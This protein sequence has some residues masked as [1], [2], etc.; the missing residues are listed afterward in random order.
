[1]AD[2]LC[3]TRFQRVRRKLTRWKRV[4]QDESVLR[5][6]CA[7]S[8]R[9]G[10]CIMW[11]TF[12][13]CPSF[14]DTLETC[15]AIGRAWT[16]EFDGASFRIGM[17]RG[18]P[19]SLR[20][21]WMGVFPRGVSW[22]SCSFFGTN[23]I[24]KSDPPISTRS[25]GRSESGSRH[26]LSRRNGST[27]RR[28]LGT[29]LIRV[30]AAVVQHPAPPHF[31]GQRY[32]LIAWVTGAES[33]S[34]GVSTS[35]GIGRQFGGFYRRPVAERTDSTQRQPPFSAKECNRIR[36]ATG[37]FWQRESYD[38]CVRDGDEL[39]RIVDYIHANPVKAGLVQRA[40]DF[41][42][43]S[44]YPDNRI[45]VGHVSNVSLE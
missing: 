1:M 26:S 19:I 27:I 7:G 45:H 2:Q 8:L 31:A 3:G 6:S 17:C 22:T 44:A 43:S 9:L 13:T 12:L 10:I 15:P 38:H 16:E 32:D 29:W 33:L 37:P 5:L 11:D 21:V 28:R 34:L 35:R 36:N 4:P 39:E 23:S 25:R 20:L 24:D 41:P 40:E 14:P 18:R 30:L 42:F